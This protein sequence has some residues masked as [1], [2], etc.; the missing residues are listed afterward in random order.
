MIIV[1]QVRTKEAIHVEGLGQLGTSFLAKTTNL[2]MKFTE[3]GVVL[4]GVGPKK[5][6]MGIIP[7]SNV[8][9]ATIDLSESVLD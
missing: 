1:S 9:S 5:G 6:H 2:E 4:K 8:V 7:L 3:L